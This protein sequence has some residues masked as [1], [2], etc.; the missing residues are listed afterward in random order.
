VALSPQVNYT[1]S[2]T[3]TGRRI[4]V[5]TIVDRA[6]SRGQRGR[7]PTAVNLSFLDRRHCFFFQVFP[8]LSS[9]GWVDPVPDPP[10]LRKFGGPENRTRDL[11]PGYPLRSTPRRPLGIVSMLPK[12]HR[13]CSE[14]ELQSGG[15]SHE[16]IPDLE[17][18][19]SFII[20][21]TNKTKTNSVALSP[22]ANYTD[23]STATCRR[24]L[25]LT[26]VDREVSCGQ[27]GG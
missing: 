27:R 17:G 8:Q 26:S 18:V 5:S 25:L 1:D 2:S 3:A 19:S 14:R 9:R 7:T 23:W 24:N 20:K 11:W 13:G 15:W 16:Q 10:L 21:V 22:Q 4:F 6:V 12:V